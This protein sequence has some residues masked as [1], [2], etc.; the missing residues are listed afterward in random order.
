MNRLQEKRNVSLIN[1]CLHG[2]NSDRADRYREL[3]SVLPTRSYYTLAS[4]AWKDIMAIQLGKANFVE[5]VSFTGKDELFEEEEY[6][7]DIL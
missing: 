4:V 3:V 2:L 7:F 5:M 1:I 6:N